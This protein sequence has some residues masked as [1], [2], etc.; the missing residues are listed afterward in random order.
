MVVVVVVLGWGHGSWHKRLPRV[1]MKNLHSPM[2]MWWQMMLMGDV[3]Q[4]DGECGEGV[5]E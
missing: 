1:I 5:S 2:M 3:D 4:D